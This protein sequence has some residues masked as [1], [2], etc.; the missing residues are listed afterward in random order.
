MAR[1]ARKYSQ[2][3]NGA[4]S[5][6]IGGKYFKLLR[7]VSAVTVQLYNRGQIVLDS[8]GVEGGFYMRGEF[9]R[10]DIVTTASELVEWLTA[11]DE[12]GSDRLT[13]TFTMENLYAA[14]LT[15]EASATVGV[16]A[17]QVLAA[18]AGRKWI[19]FRARTGNTADIV[20]GAAAVTLNG[21]IRLAAGTEISIESASPAAWYGISSGAGQNLD[22]LS[23]A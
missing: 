9:D 19:R 22:I 2:T 17:A 13:G 7:T 1:A 15:N 21:A 18:S 5:L 4:V 12:A 11:D 6:N 20:L 3:F 8:A 23:G 16:A 14:T 10:V